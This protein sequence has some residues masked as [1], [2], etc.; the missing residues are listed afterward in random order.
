MAETLFP[1][2]I[3]LDAG[4]PKNRGTGDG[5]T[6][7][8]WQFAML[9]FTCTAKATIEIYDD[10]AP[11]DAAA[12]VTATF[13]IMVVNLPTNGSWGPPLNGRKLKFLRGLYYKIT[14]GSDVFCGFY[15]S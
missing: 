3:S 2:I 7:R 14:Q 12:P 13:P 10:E 1:D 9:H 4:A 11:T 15:G 8:E 5:V 6:L